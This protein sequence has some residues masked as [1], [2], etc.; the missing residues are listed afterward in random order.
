MAGDIPDP[1]QSDRNIDLF[2]IGFSFSD[3]FNNGSLLGYAG[4][5][6]GWRH[7]FN[8]GN[9]I[10]FGRWWRGAVRTIIKIK[11]AHDKKDKYDNRKPGATGF[12]QVGAA[13]ITN[14]R[15]NGIFDAALRA[16]DDFRVF[17]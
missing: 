1:K 17:G 15:L 9:K 14:I 2:G 5:C 12:F 7:R 6:R 10:R 13:V 3:G 11:H 8:F 16:I 4:S